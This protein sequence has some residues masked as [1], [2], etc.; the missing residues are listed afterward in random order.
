MYTGRVAL[1][2][3]HFPPLCQLHATYT[4]LQQISTCIF[5]DILLREAYSANAYF[6]L[7]VCAPCYVWGE[8]RTARFISDFVMLDLLLAVSLRS[9][10]HSITCSDSKVAPNQAGWGSNSV[11]KALNYLCWTVERALLNSRKALYVPS[12]KFFPPP[13]VRC[14]PL[15]FVGLLSRIY[16]ELPKL[17]T[18]WYILTMMVYTTSLGCVYRRRWLLS[19]CAYSS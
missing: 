13:K 16:R 3:A 12:D 19:A 14:G 4:W 6:Q 2:L 9:V 1:H 10:T 7:Y 17:G 5:P 8:D 15:L 11:I 18:Y